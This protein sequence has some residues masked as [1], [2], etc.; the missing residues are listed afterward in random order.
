MGV[1]RHDICEQRKCFTGMKK[2]LMLHLILI[3][4][5]RLAAAYIPQKV[6]TKTCH[7]GQHAQVDV[8]K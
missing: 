4:I 7:F 1:A 8:V 2:K 3:L 5:S 6:I